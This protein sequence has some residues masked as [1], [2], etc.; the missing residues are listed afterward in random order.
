MP[1]TV[2][3]PHLEQEHDEF[4]DPMNLTIEPYIA[5]S[6]TTCFACPAIGFAG[7]LPA[8][9]RLPLHGREYVGP[10]LFHCEQQ[11]PQHGR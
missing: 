2:S 9:R 10:A 6:C 5:E 4:F 8:I 11:F 1:R 3:R 7:F